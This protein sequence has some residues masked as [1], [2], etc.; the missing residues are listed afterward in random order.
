MK[1]LFTY[2]LMFVAATGFS[3]QLP[4]YSQYYNNPM[5][6]NPGFT[7]NTENIE[8]NVIHRNQ[9]K[10]IP[11]APVTSVMS[12]DGTTLD[13]KVGL[14]LIIMDDKMGLFARRGIY[15]SYSYKIQ[16]ATDHYIKPGI[17]FGM[18][19]VMIDFSRAN[20][21]DNND[22][23]LYSNTHRKSSFDANFGVAYNWKELNAG[24]S[25]M[26]LF[27][28]KFRL[29]NDTGSYYRAT[30]KI[31]IY[32]SYVIPI[33]K[34]NKINA[35]PCMALNINPRGPFQA[36]IFANFDYDEMIY[37]GIGYRSSST[38]SFNLGFKWN[39]TLRLSYNYDVVVGK[40]KGYTGGSHEILLGYSFGKPGKGETKPNDAYT[41]NDNGSKVDSL[42]NQV[43]KLKQEM[44]IVK[45]EMDYQKKGNVADQV[46]DD[47]VIQYA[48]DY[49]DYNGNVPE[50]GFYVVL[51]QFKTLPQAEADEKELDKAGIHS[52]LLL[53]AIKG[54][55]VYSQILQDRAA[56]DEELKKVRWK[57]I[58]SYVLEL[59]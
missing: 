46:K 24:V 50:K 56:A 39:K 8:A 2:M 45:A 43:N 51:G 31:N 3:Q 27:G 9:W 14:G 22:P 4:L 6:I 23:N 37:A 29:N 41:S 49:K 1:N 18:Q 28:N 16:V 32:G 20:I 26:Q 57:R 15:T 19:D 36:D 10:S 44:Q 35:R 54:Y 42:Q 38:L 30:Q 48:K 11:G 7:G 40:L 58:D 52:S 34:E 13:E 53:H 25:V 21:S 59:K 33:S 17:S 47:L 12:V 55:F 5:L